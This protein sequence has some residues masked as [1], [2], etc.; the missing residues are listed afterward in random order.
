MGKL[1]VNLYGKTHYVT[2]CRNLKFYVEQG[3]VLTEIHRILSFT[4]RPWFKP[5][6]DLCT[7]QRQ[8]AQ[9]D[10][11]KLQANATYGKTM[12]QDRNRVIIRL[13]ADDTKLLKAVSKLL[14]LIW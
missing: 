14:T 4:Q 3:L 1:I 5:W 9:S 13:I 11:A 8:N 10:L 12:E 2:H 6:I 7:S